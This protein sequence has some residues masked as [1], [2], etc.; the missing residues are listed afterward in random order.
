MTAQVGGRE[1]QVDRL[2]HPNGTGQ[3][4][5][6]TA[7]AGNTLAYS[8][9]DVEYL[10]PLGCG[11]GGSCKKKIAGGGIDLVTAGQKTPLPGA[12]PAL[13]LAVSA[14]RVAYIP[15]TTVVRGGVPAS[16]P[17]VTIPVED[18]SNGAIVSQ[19]KAI[20]TPIAIGLS[21][22]ILAVLSHGPHGMRLTWYDPATGEKIDGIT[23]PA[24]TAELAVSDQVIVFRF[25]RALRSVVPATGHVR[26]L[27]K[28][29]AQYL[30]L[31]LD[32]GRLVWAENHR[33]SGRIRALQ[34]T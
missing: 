8:W 27:G 26:A 28:T 17:S 33:S 32:A 7:G 2:A 3:F 5:G 30:G 29:A 22:H 10:D 16:N 9:V 24:Q 4:L 21:P 6:A 1:I 23:V 31:S 34:V 20:G 11:S 25:G 15:A 12:G 13:G 18:A 19:P 14:G